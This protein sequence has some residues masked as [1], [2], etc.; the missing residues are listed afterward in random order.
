MKSTSQLWVEVCGFKD[1]DVVGWGKPCGRPLNGVISMV[2][3]WMSLAID[4]GFLRCDFG[5]GCKLS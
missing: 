5:Y 2:V 4:R 1:R 3:V